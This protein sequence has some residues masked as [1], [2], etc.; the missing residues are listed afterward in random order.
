[1]LVRCV[2]GVL[3]LCVTFHESPVVYWFCLLLFVCWLRV[4]FS[5]CGVCVSV[6]CFA[7][8]VLLS[9]VAFVCC[10]ACVGPACR[11]WLRLLLVCWL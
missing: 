3:V 2:V 4:I 11:C 1:M 5:V 10:F 9:C 7:L 8:R 6:P